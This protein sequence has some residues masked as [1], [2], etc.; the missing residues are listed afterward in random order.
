MLFYFETNSQHSKQ[1]F[2]FHVSSYCFSIAYLSI[3][4]VCVSV[5]EFGFIALS[6][7]LDDETIAI[8]PV[9][10]VAVGECFSRSHNTTQ[11][12]RLCGERKKLQM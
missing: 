1:T 5:C 9:V 3:I 7:K 6:V 8:V 12:N 10:V 2:W 11:D 4:C